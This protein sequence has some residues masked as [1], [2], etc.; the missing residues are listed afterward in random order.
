MHGWTFHEFLDWALAEASAR[1][2]WTKEE[3]AKSES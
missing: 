1:L 2:E 3:V